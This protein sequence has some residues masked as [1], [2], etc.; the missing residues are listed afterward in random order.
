MSLLKTDDM[1]VVRLAVPEKKTVTESI[2][3]GEILFQCLEG[4]VAFTA[5]GKTQ[6]L[7][8]GNLLYLPIG[9]PFTVEGIEDAS[10]LLTILL[11][12]R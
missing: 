9:E 12:K 7:E 5:Y 3:K 6:M 2:T 11:P 8:T 4:K 1:E 10:L